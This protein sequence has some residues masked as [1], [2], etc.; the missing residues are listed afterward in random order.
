MTA[1]SLGIIALRV[2]LLQLTKKS[3]VLILVDVW[4]HSSKVFKAR[5]TK[6]ASKRLAIDLKKPKR[7]TKA[8]TKSKA[9]SRTKRKSKSKKRKSKGKM[10]MVSFVP[11]SGPNKGKRIRFKVK[12]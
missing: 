9:R 11:K 4:K 2:G 7:K 3:L 12:A 6:M 8:K 1:A 5:I 10:K